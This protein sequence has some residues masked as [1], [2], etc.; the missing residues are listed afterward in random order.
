MDEEE[1][2]ALPE[3]EKEKLMERYRVK[4]RQMKLRYEL[5]EA[6]TDRHFRFPLELKLSENV[7]VLGENLDIFNPE[8]TSHDK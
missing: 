8:Y 5:L 4:L 6:D 3:A 1:Y 2:D 7:T